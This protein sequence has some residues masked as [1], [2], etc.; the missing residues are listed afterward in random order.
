MVNLAAD[1]E[2][3]SDDETGYENPYDYDPNA[4]DDNDPTV[5]GEDPDLGFGEPD[6]EDTAEDDDTTSDDDPEYE[7]E[8][9][10]SDA[11]TAEIEP[12]YDNVIDWVEGWFAE[13]IR[14]KLG[15]GGGEQGLAWD[16]RWWLYPEVT[17]RFTALWYAWEEARASDKASA[18]SNW[19]V[20]HLEPHLRVIFDS[21]TGPMSHAKDD[22]S[23]SGWP[24]LPTQQVPAEQRAILIAD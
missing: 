4:F 18:M 3:Q 8:S 10:E 14:R 24:A 19:W 16:Q 20:H 11:E 22:G 2:W 13:V 12:M 17:G 6:A 21:D 5:E 1:D 15:A 23:F 7:G 9:D